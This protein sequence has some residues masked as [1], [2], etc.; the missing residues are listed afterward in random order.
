MIFTYI[1]VNGGGN[2]K[3]A[4]INTEYCVLSYNLTMKR[5]NEG[6]VFVLRSLFFGIGGE[7]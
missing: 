4:V 5:Q 6:M 2:E 1:P 7:S 3:R